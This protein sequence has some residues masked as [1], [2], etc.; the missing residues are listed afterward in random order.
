M[1]SVPHNTTQETE[2]DEGEADDFQGTAITRQQAAEQAKSLLAYMLCYPDAFDRSAVRSME[3]LT[4]QL[5]HMVVLHQTQST[6]QQM[7]QRQGVSLLFTGG[8]V[9][10]SLV[11]TLTAA[12]ML[13][14]LVMICAVSVCFTGLSFKV[15]GTTL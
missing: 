10:C 13:F 14:A 4:R 9:C 15:C 1:A 6:L 2:S 7:W 11:A 8:P 3:S 12:S 5:A